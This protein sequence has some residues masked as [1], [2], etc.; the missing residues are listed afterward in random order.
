M[1]QPRGGR[2]TTLRVPVEWVFSRWGSAMGD[3]M[4][5]T[6]EERERAE[7][8]SRTREW[9]LLVGV[10]WEAV[11]NLLALTTGFSALL[12]GRMARVAPARVGSTLPF[13]ALWL[14][15]SFLTS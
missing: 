1:G 3:E 12:R 4:Y 11:G 14:L 10:V 15:R 5:A 7:R 6:D 9:L 13:V 2:A 8:Y